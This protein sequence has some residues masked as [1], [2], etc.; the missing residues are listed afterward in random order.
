MFKD[1]TTS[2][3]MIGRLVGGAVNP[4]GSIEYSVQDGRAL[5]VSFEWLLP[6][7]GLGLAESGV[8]RRVFGIVIVPSTLVFVASG[9]TVA[10]PGFGSARFACTITAT[11]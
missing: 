11:S 4:A 7:T 5:S 10:I 2:V 8:D 1:P 3:G 6:L 9:S